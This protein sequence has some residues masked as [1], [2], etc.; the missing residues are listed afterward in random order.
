MSSALDSH[1]LDAILNPALLL[2]LKGVPDRSGVG[3]GHGLGD[4]VG[5]GVG[6][7][8]TRKLLAYAAS[9]MPGAE[10]ATLT[11]NNKTD[12]CSSGGLCT[13]IFSAHELYS[14]L[15]DHLT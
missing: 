2:V 4:G 5:A 3:A 13:A 8:V 12:C 1:S 7:S 14:F 10:S 6:K 9:G 15:F 11:A